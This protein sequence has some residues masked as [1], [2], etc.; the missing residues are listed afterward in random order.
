M[1]ENSPKS[2]FFQEYLVDFLGGLVPGTL[3]CIG[4]AVA[5][6]PPLHA[7]LGASLFPMIKMS[8][9]MSTM[10]N[11]LMATKGTPNTIWVAVFIAACSLSYVFGHLFYRA[12]A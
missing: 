2:T 5:L 8:P 6:V 3:F 10:K 11:V 1:S 7:L 4:A 12:Y 9:L